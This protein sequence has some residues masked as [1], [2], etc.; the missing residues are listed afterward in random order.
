MGILDGQYDV[1]LHGGQCII[2]PPDPD[3]QNDELHDEQYMGLLDRQ[4]KG[5]YV[6]LLDGQ[7]HVDVL[8]D[9]YMGPVD[10]Q[11]DL[12]LHDGHYMDLSDG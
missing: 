5:C 2:L 8:H 6:G 10:G 4:H 11:Y 3:R 1:L 12:L 7:Y 9:G